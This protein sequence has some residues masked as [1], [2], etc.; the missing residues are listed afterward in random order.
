MNPPRG[1][2]GKLQYGRLNVDL[3]LKRPVNGTFCGNFPEAI[4]LF[5]VEVSSH[6]DFQIDAVEKSLFGFAILTVLGM[7]S[8][9]GSSARNS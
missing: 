9:I 5:G 3:R 7:N 1:K 4:L 8:I 6:F 2:D